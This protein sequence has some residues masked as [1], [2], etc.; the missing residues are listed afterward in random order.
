MVGHVCGEETMIGDKLDRPVRLAVSFDVEVEAG[1]GYQQALSACILAAGLP[2]D[3]C[4]P[5]FFARSRQ[6]V[7]ALAAHGIEA[8]HL[9]FGVWARRESLVWSI[10]GKDRRGAKLLHAIRGSSPFEKALGDSADLIYFTS[11]TALAFGLERLSYLATIW[12]EAHRDDLEFPEV[13]PS[14]ICYQRERLHRETVLRAAGVFV[15]SQ[16]S[17]TMLAHRYGIDA[18]RIHVLPFSPAAHIGNATG[19][20]DGASIKERYRLDCHYVF[21]PAQFWAH[22]NHV[23]VLRALKRIETELGRRVGAIFSGADKGNQAYVMEVANMLGLT[24]RVRFANFVGNAEIPELYRGSLA[25]VMPTYFGP[26]NLPPLEAFSLGV[27]VIYSD[28]PGLRDQVGDAALLVDLNDPGALAAAIVRIQDDSS[29]RDFLIAEG[30][31]QLSN[32][33]DESRRATLCKVLSNFRS[34]RICWA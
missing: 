19:A 16:R 28:K 4:M 31:R 1:G 3:L 6:N 34:R 15:D 27:P 32:V 26:T 33:T 14:W 8:R 7:E 20:G 25:L 13:R 23:Y 11:P 21:Y 5:R 22:K 9:S 29:L 24:D 10:V 18:G 30:K 12:D 17:R 2:T